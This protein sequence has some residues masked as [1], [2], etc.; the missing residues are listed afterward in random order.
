MASEE[1]K[2]PSCPSRTAQMPTSY[3]LTSITI[4]ST[5]RPTCPPNCRCQ[6]HMT[7]HLASPP[8][9]RAALG[10]LMV[11][12]RSLPMLG[13]S[14]CNVPLCNSASG[15]SFRLHYCFPQWLVARALQVSMS[16]GSP[17]D[18]GASIFLRMPRSVEMFGFLHNFSTPDTIIE[19]HLRLGDIRP[20][21]IIIHSGQ[22]AL[23]V[24]SYTSTSG[25]ERLSLM[26]VPDLHEDRDMELD[27]TLSPVWVRP[28]LC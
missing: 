19:D 13:T 5:L 9:A 1:R 6:C 26:L 23:T 17:T 28:D 22:T 25:P 24:C 10:M 7:S 11:N 15:S 21:D 18:G 3:S 20:T 4:T 14:R 16:W 8:W 2:T 12:Y 27:S